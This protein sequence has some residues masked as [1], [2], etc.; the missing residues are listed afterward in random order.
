MF[1]I[2]DLILRAFGLSL[3]GLDMIW[4]FEQIR[5]FAYTERQGQIK[6]KIKENR[7]LYELGD[8]TRDEYERTNS[9][10]TQKLKLAERVNEMNLNSRLNI[11]GK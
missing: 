3:P 2:D 9:V 10:L 7:M 6:D 4:L 11:L 8:I 5:N 1:I